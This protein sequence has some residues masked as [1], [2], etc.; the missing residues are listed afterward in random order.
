MD[1]DCSERGKR[2][3]RKSIS[4][5]GTGNLKDE[6]MKGKARGNNFKLMLSLL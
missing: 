5:R 2:E 1:E 4:Q 3:M 6:R